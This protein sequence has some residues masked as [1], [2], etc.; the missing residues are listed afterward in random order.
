MVNV[1]TT[2]QC[3]THAPV[4][5]TGPEIMKQERD[6]TGALASAAGYWID[7]SHLEMFNADGDV[8][9]KFTAVSLEGTSW[10]LH[11]YVNSAGTL[12]GVEY[13]LL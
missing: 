2:D 9:L 12:V 8:I 11:S 3:S 1:I 13:F 7:G 10:E 6:Y 5:C 4:P